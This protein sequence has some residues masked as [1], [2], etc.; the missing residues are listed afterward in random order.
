MSQT[1]KQNLDQSNP[2]LKASDQFGGYK[3]GEFN[4]GAQNYEVVPQTG[5]PARSDS[6]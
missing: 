4:K 6:S 1:P 5:G 2:N 3:V